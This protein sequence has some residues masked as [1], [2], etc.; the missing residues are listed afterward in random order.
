MTVRAIATLTLALA[1]SS[2]AGCGDKSQVMLT[3]GLGSPELTVTSNSLVTD[4]MGS[5]DLE[6]ALGDRASD[7]TTVQIGPFSLQRDGSV[8][9]DPLELATDPAFPIDV[10]VGRSKHVDVTVTNPDGDAAL[11]DTLCSAELQIVGTLT[12]SLGDGSLT[13]TSERFMPECP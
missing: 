13:V 6:L 12:D 3:A 4:V 7:P 9:L 1:T 5:F 11:V 2:L 10:G 8:L